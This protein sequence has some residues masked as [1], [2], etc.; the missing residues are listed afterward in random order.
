MKETQR[1]RIAAEVCCHTH[2][3]YTYQYYREGWVILNACTHTDEK[4][5]Q[6]LVFSV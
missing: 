5:E 6:D 4:E 2:S 1:T 3:V